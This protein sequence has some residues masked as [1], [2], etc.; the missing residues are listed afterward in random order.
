M[1]RSLRHISVVAMSLIV[2]AIAR[3]AAAAQSRLPADSLE[4]IRRYTDS[5]LA[6]EIDSVWA[7]VNTRGRTAFTR[8]AL[9][10]RRAMLLQVTGGSFDFVEERFVWRNGAR[11]VG[12]MPGAPAAAAM[13]GKRSTSWTISVDTCAAGMRPGQRITHGVRMQPSIAEL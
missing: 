11:T 7:H 9:V 13:V 3:R 2:C 8:D 12:T 6:G 10:E 5:F 1:R 4:R